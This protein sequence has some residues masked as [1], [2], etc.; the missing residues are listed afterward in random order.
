MS[1]T[2]TVTSNGNSVSRSG[3]PS[4][5][6][7]LQDLQDQ[8]DGI[9]VGA[10]AL[11]DLTDVTITTP[12]TNDV[13]KYNGSGWVNGSVSATDSAVGCSCYKSNGGGDQT[14]T[15]AN[16]VT[17]TLD[18]ES[19][20]TSACHSTSSNTGRH[21]APSDGYYFFGY[22]ATVTGAGNTTVHKYVGKNGSQTNGTTDYVYSG[23]TF[24]MT[25]F[26][27][28]YLTAGDYL[29]AD[30]YSADANLTIKCRDAFNGRGAETV[31]FKV[32]A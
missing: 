2:N 9:S 32:G 8:I 26:A 25:H 16:F 14:A 29:T 10:S 18:S 12:A 1:Y 21:V 6:E 22:S 5:D 23:A 27:I 13:I 28:M 4:F 3:T 24:T 11:D 31:F 17:I 20:D 15:A 19:F 7:Q 30:L